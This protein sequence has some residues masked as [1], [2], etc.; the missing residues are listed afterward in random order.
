M[1]EEATFAAILAIVKDLVVTLAAAG[2]LI[3]TLLGLRTWKRQLKG[4]TEWDLA[5]RYLR[6]VYIVRDAVG[7]VRIS[8]MSVGEQSAAMAE[9]KKARSDS[10]Q[11][12]ID[13]VGAAYEQRFVPLHRA[14]S[15]LQVER[16]EA[17]ALWGAAAVEAIKP[18]AKSMRELLSYLEMHMRHRAGRMK[19]AK[20]DLLDKIDGV[21][22]G[23]P[24]EN[25]RDEFG[26]DL[27]KAVGT[28]EAFIR[29]SRMKI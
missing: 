29:P 20:Q 8:F 15:D 18:L 3:V 25:G 23:I 26:D 4:K 5:R 1:S 16:A 2:G 6:A 11:T 13:P 7:T 22:F 10:L 9:V 12:D 28:A 17:E 14:W 24:N 21:M 27:S 19:G